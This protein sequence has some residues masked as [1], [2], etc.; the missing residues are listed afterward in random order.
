MERLNSIGIGVAGAGRIGGE[1]I[2]QSLKD[3]SLNKVFNIT[4]VL[5]RNIDRKRAN[6]IPPEIL[7]SDANS[8]LNDSHIRIAVSLMG[9]E[10]AEKEFILRALCEGKFVV[11]ANKEVI[12]K[13]GPE[14]IE[15]A[16]ENNT[17]IFFEAAVC[18]GIQIIDNLIT[19]YQF[20]EFQYI[21]GIINGTTNYIL[22]K[23]AQEGC[24]QELALEQAKALDY[25]EPNPSNDID[26]HDSRYK[27]AILASLTFRKGWVDPKD[28][29]TESIRGI[30]KIDIANARNMGYVIKQIAQARIVNETLQAWV[31]PTLIPKQHLLADVNGSLNGL[32]LF[33]KPIEEIKLQGRGAGAGPTSSSIWSDVL[34]ASYHIES[35]TLPIMPNIKSSAEILPFGGYQNSHYIRMT[36]KDQPGVLAE[37]SQILG[38]N[39][40][41]ISRLIQPEGI[42]GIT[43]I[44]FL[45]HPSKEINFQNALE[46][47]SKEKSVIK[48]NSV[49]GVNK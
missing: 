29:H 48:I 18:G 36:V 30:D 42:G 37:I 35:H 2:E 14:I 10:N 25:A 49:L 28:I 4:R 33:G 44:I 12:A 13:Y 21:Q 31:G 11:T 41:S 16:E 46:K 9:E 38:N 47:I 15:K 26:G 23:M 43:E 20:N 8:I 27:L 1:I 34:K 45:T 32:L 24:D 39:N 17:G 40:I 22:T 6:D 5:V 7:T 19:R 3:E